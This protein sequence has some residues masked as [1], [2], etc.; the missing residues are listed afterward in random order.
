[1]PSFVSGQIAALG[2]FFHDAL[3]GAVTTIAA[4]VAAFAIGIVLGS[5]LLVVRLHGGRVLAGLGLVYVHGVRRTPALF[6]ML[7]GDHV[8]P[9]G[10]Q[11][12]PSPLPA[13]P[14]PLPV[15][16]PPHRFHVLRA[17]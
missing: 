6:P 7:G 9:S 2:P 1:M 4:S 15:N 12:P 8:L 3:G 13:R 16:T 10:A 17:A 14:L 5:I 11:L